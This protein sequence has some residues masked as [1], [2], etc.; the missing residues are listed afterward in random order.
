MALA[1]KAAVGQDG[2]TW[3]DLRGIYMERRGRV[4][5]CLSREEGKRPAS[6]RRGTDE[7]LLVLK[8]PD[9][10]RPKK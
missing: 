8:R 1:S 5:I 3:S 9:P 7:V 6:F 2:F 4:H 10:A